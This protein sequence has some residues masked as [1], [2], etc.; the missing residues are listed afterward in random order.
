M[1]SIQGELRA[2][3]ANSFFNVWWGCCDM[4][5]CVW[6]RAYLSSPEDHQSPKQPRTGPIHHS[7]VMQ[8]CV[9]SL[10]SHWMVTWP[11]E[12]MFPQVHKLPVLTHFWLYPFLVGKALWLLHE[13]H[14]KN[15]SRFPGCYIK[16]QPI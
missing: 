10:M 2:L 7:S 12:L 4:N 11:F 1:E 15:S 5:F 13:K 6:R 8:R 16:F 3:G 14:W 9:F